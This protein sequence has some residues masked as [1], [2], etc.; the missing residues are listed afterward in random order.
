MIIIA[1]SLVCL[2]IQ[3]YTPSM[4]TV[5]RSR[6]YLKGGPSDLGTKILQNTKKSS[7]Y[8]YSQN[9]LTLIHITKVVENHPTTR[10]IRDF[11]RPSQ[12]RRETRSLIYI[13]E[14]RRRSFKHKV[15]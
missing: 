12:H 2:V 3:D 7:L 6:L 5:M 1:Q 11:L 9:L 15:H 4:F 8:E 10:E 14:I 13:L